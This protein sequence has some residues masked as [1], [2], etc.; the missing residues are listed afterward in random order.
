MQFLQILMNDTFLSNASSTIQSI[1]NQ[2]T[3]S[4]RVNE[5]MESIE[6]DSQLIH[7]KD[8]LIEVSLS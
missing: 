3:N 8:E 5:S 6:S 1:C 2:W 4:S 7:E